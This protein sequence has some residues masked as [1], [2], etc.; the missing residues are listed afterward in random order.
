VP[1]HP[2]PPQAPG[3]YPWQAMVFLN[4]TMGLPHENVETQP[5]GDGAS[6]AMGGG[7]ATAQ[8]NPLR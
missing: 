7:T 4:K 6:S 8:E 1:A 2:L 3:P 5:V